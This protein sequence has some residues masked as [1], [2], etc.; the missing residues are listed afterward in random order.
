[1]NTDVH[2]KHLDF[3]EGFQ[4]GLSFNA[5]MEPEKPWKMKGIILVKTVTS[6]KEQQNLIKYHMISCKKVD[7]M[8]RN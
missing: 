7:E 1:M 6:C 5:F 8:W 3:W 2:K 4:Q